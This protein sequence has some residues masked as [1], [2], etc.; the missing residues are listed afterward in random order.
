[1]TTET[2]PGQGTT[3]PATTAMTADPASAS[4]QPAQGTTDP[5]TTQPQGQGEQAKP[6]EGE[7]KPEDK[8]GDKPVEFEDFTAPEGIELDGELLGEFKSVATELKLPQEAAQKLVDIG[9]K[10]VQRQVD[11]YHA[12]QKQWVEAITADKEI[13]GDK[14]NESKA[15]VAK[16]MNAFATPEL[17]QMLKETGMGNN[18]E[19]FKFA[20]RIGKA[21]SEDGFVKGQ[22]GGSAPADPA[23][24]FYPT[25]KS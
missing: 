3:D 6:G 17:R 7:Q 25:M 13:G 5:A 16:T 12:T 22:P 1:M 9:A 21:I 4:T 18:P 19:L 23:A 15:L 14:L 8:A 20:H 10:L 11:A 24:S 2:A